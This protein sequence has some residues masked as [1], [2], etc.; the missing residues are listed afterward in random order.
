[1]S[2][3][4]GHVSRVLGPLHFIW[5]IEAKYKPSTHHKFCYLNFDITKWIHKN[6]KFSNTIRAIRSAE[7][8]KWPQCNLLW[9]VNQWKDWKSTLSHSFIM[10]SERYPFL[11]GFL[12]W[13]FQSQ[14]CI[15]ISKVCGGSLISLRRKLAICEETLCHQLFHTFSNL[16]L[17]ARALLNLTTRW[18]SSTP[19]HCKI[20][21]DYALNRGFKS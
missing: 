1:M 11:S 5:W 12:W 3:W 6:V 20:L 15:G 21:F 14:R 16:L 8:A 9:Y 2:N 17:V 7:V 4:S 13:L 18:C 10:F 19:D